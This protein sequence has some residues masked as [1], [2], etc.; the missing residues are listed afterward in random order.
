MTATKYIFLVFAVSAC[1]T[2]KPAYTGTYL[3]AEDAS[4]WAIEL[5]EDS[6]FVYKTEGHVGSIVLAG[7]IDFVGDTL[8]LQPTNDYQSKAKQLVYILY[9]DSCLI[10]LDYLAKD[11]IKYVRDYCKERNEN[12][13]SGH[14]NLDTLTP[15]PME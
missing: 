4:F 15:L 14:W 7:R 9:K 3:G 5:L 2:N 12:W 8:F 6:T 10:S 11:G 1:Q 13:T